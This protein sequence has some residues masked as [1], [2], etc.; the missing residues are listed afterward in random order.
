[1][2]QFAE[3][4][5][6]VTACSRPRRMRSW[7]TITGAA[8]TRLVVKTPAAGDRR[9]GHDHPEVLASRLLAQSGADAGE[10]KALHRL[11]VPESYLHRHTSGGDL[12]RG[13]SATAQAMRPVAASMRASTSELT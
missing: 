11:A 9:I 1:M 5:L 7:V 10:A 3:P 6:A 2:K 8:L 13:A 4:E 12:I